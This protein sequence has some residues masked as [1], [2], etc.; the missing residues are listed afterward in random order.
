MNDIDGNEVEVG[1]L[2][3]VLSVDSDF[4]GLLEDETERKHH[5]AMLNNT[6]HIDEIVEDGS[7]ASVSIQWECAEG[8][9]TGGLYLLPHE[10]R[11]ENIK[12][13]G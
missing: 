13:H 11:L 1:D 3:R 6:Y 5:L 10:F 4:L 9:A 8:I 2:I 7:K 12:P